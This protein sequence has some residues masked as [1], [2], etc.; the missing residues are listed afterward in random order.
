MRTPL[1]LNAAARSAARA[2]DVTHRAASSD[3]MNSL[4]R[5]GYATRAFLYVMVGLLA[6]EV[7]VGLGGRAT[8]TRGAVNSVAEIG[9]RPLDTLLLALVTLG[10]ICYSL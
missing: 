1:P 5:L 7:V 10:L 3:W 6:L 9:S 2:R 4:A 8:G